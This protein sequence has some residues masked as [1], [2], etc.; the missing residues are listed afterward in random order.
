MSALNF[1]ANG[2]GLAKAGKSV[3]L[4]LT[5]V[6]ESNKDIKFSLYSLALLAPNRCYMQPVNYQTN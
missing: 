3:F 1:A 6:P 5:L 2:T 4:L